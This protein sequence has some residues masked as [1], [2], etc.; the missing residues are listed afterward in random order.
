MKRFTLS[1][2]E[3]LSSRKEIEILFLEGQSLT[4]YP[5]RLVW[6]E[7]ICPTPGE[8]PLRMMFSV[9]KKKFPKAVDRNRAKRLMKEGYRLLK[10][11]IISTIAGQKYFHLGLIYTGSELLD[12]V[13]IQKS[14]SIALERW[15]QKLQQETR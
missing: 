2:Q 5:V 4:K 14:I 3:R 1:K 13:T 15:M 12:F 10:P 6:R 11:E 8:A 7:A 9:S